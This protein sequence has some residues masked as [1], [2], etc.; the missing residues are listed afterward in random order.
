MPGR[1]RITC[2]HVRMFAH[3]KAVAAVQCVPPRQCDAA[4][5]MVRLD[6]LDRCGAATA[7]VRE[8]QF[9][10]PSLRLQELI[11]KRS[12]KDIETFGAKRNEP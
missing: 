1:V 3:T 11:D 2:S 6:R 8:S 9:H 10:V 4:I 5:A 12:A 7:M